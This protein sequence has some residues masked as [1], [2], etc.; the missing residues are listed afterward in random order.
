MKSA[1]AIRQQRHRERERDGRQIVTV[2]TDGETIELLIEARLLDPHADFHPR[3]KIG[4]AIE[5]FLILARK[6]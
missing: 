2:E 5:R 1:N 3:E 6:A 4:T